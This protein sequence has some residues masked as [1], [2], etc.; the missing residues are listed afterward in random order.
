[1]QADKRQVRNELQRTLPVTSVAKVYHQFFFARAVDSHGN[2]TR[3]RAAE[4][5]KIK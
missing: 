4:S 3:P 5:V 1:M 2:Y